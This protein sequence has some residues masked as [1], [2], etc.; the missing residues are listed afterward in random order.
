MFH[1]VNG[2]CEKTKEEISSS[3][4]L[5]E[6]L[7][8]EEQYLEKLEKNWTLE[9]YYDEYKIEHIRCVHIPVEME[10]DSE[11]WEIVRCDGE[12]SPLELLVEVE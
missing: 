8:L 6:T 12:E 4:L 5:G 11:C 3:R 9:K 2:L 7:E 10:D 1:E